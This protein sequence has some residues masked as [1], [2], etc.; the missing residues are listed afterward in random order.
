VIVERDAAGTG[1]ETISGKSAV[2]VFSDFVF[3]VCDG[4]W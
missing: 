4:A 1:L 3:G 2:V